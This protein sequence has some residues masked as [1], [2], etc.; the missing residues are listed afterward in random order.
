MVLTGLTMSPAVTASH[1]WLLTMFMGAQSARTIHFF[2]AVILVLF[3]LVHVVMIVK[4]GFRKQMLQMTI[5]S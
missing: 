5:Q 1:P 2:A 3:L 4:T